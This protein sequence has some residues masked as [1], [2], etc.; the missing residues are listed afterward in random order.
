MKKFTNELRA[1]CACILVGLAIT[2][3]SAGGTKAVNNEA[4][5]WHQK[6]LQS[7]EE[8][9]LW[10]DACHMYWQFGDYDFLDD[11][12]WEPV[13]RHNF[14]DDCISETDTYDKLDSIQGGDWEDFFFDW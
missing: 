1:L 14:W 5:Y 13:G 12:T 9:M 3:A 8:L 4:E 6:Y 11:E 2:L 7:Q 10:R